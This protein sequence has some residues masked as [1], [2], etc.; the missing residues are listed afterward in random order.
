L[1]LLCSIVWSQVL[2]SRQHWTFCTKWLWLFDVFC[3]SI[4]T[5]GFFFISLKNV[6]GVL[7]SILLN[8]YILLLI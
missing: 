5:L 7:M 4:W 2:W 8:M 1:L 3:T 6:V